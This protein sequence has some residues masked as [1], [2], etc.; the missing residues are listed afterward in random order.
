MPPV[1]PFAARHPGFR[2]GAVLTPF[3]IA[4]LAACGGGGGGG[5]SGASS[6][7][8]TGSSSSSSAAPTAYVGGSEILVNTATDNDQNAIT[9]TT[10][11]NGNVVAGWV[12]SQGTIGGI[13]LAEIRAQILTSDGAKSGSEI[14]ASTGTRQSS[15]SYR[16]VQPSLSA[17]NGGGFG[18]LY[19]SNGHLNTTN[20]T[21]ITSGPIF[22]REFSASGAALGDAVAPPLT[23]SIQNGI[24]YGNNGTQGQPKLVR[25]SD[26]RLLATWTEFNAST[27]VG[28]DGDSLS[29][30]AQLYSADADELTPAFI[31]NTSTAGQQSQSYAAPLSNGGFVITWLDYNGSAGTNVVNKLRAQIFNAAG[32]KVGGEF[33]VKE[34]PGF[35]QSPGS[36]SALANGAF[37]IVWSEGNSGSTTDEAYGQIFDASGNRVGTAFTLATNTTGR[38]VA[39][40]VITLPNGQFIAAWGDNSGTLG[41]TDGWAIKAQAFDASGTKFG[42]ELLVNVYVTGNQTSM[43]L[44]PLKTNG[45]IASWVDNSGAL[46]DTSGTAIKAR[47]FKLN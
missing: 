9:L 6:V 46:G 26:G 32:Q 37:V 23:Y 39:P 47:V 12:S 24:S 34:S 27:A 5:G 17:L 3:L 44:S 33:V 11:D 42:S 8:G 21:A 2:L 16:H 31:V 30:R 20:Q 19:V 14:I 15:S 43:V 41:D 10:L 13:A 36:V 18:L 28:G 1:Q 22:A 45:F 40:Y 35:L 4:A 25:L 38:Q 7:G 29:V